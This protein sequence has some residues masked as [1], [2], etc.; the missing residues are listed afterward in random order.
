MARD[1]YGGDYGMV[2]YDSDYSASGS[3]KYN[4][5]MAGTGAMNGTVQGAQ[6]GSAAGP[7][8]A[9]VGGIVG[10]IGGGIKGLFGADKR[11]KAEDARALAWDKAQQQ[12]A[13]NRYQ[14]R[15]LATQNVQRAYSPVNSSLGDMYGD[16]RMI[17][18]D[19][20]WANGGGP[21]PAEAAAPAKKK[22]KKAASGKASGRK[23]P[24]DR[25][26]STPSRPKN[27]TKPKVK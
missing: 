27:G 2:G 25:E 12:L 15:V 11:R 20:P 3:R 1:Q 19:S 18:M 24:V 14:S 10:G 6:M 13:K 5:E 8:G 17:N 9:L 23:T 21:S 26:N 22:P 7:W 4:G 16:R